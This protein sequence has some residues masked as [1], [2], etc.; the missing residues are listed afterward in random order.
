MERGRGP[1]AGSRQGGAGPRMSRDVRISK[2]VPMSSAQR[3]LYLQCQRP[4]GDRAYHL[5][6]LARLRGPFPLDA[7]RAFAGRMAERHESLRGAFRMENGEFLCEV[8]ETVNVAFTVID[9]AES[10]LEAVVE[11]YDQPFRLDVP[12]LFRIVI[13]RL[14]G[15][16]SILLFN[17]HHLVFDGYSGSLIARDILLELE[18]RALP[19]IERT[20]SDFVE[21]ERNFFQ[22]VEYERQRDFWLARYPQAPRRLGFRPDFAPTAAKSFAGDY[23]IVHLD[24]RE[25]KAFSRSQGATLFMTLLAAFY[26][27]LHRL[28]GQDEITVG[29][30]VSPREA[31]GFQNVVG[32]FANTLPLTCRPDPGTGFSEFLQGVR[33]MVFQA[34]QNADYPFE[35]LV[36]Q[37]PFREPGERNPLF[38]VVF[39]FE[40][41]AQR[42]VENFRGVGMETLDVFAKVSMFDLAIDLV[43]YEDQVRFKVE[44]ATSVFREE[45]L[46]GLMDAFI[47]VIEQVCRRPDIPIGE[48]EMLSDAARERL[49]GFND[50]AHPLKAGWTFVDTWAQQAARSP[51]NPALRRE[52][53]TL[54]YGQLEARANR[55]ARYLLER[56]VGEGSV[57]AVALGRTPEWIVALLALWKIGAVYLPIDPEHPAGRIRHML[58]DSGAALVL[59]L[60]RW[61]PGFAG[62]PRVLALDSLAAGPAGLPSDD[63]GRRPRPDQP[64]YI[65]YT[66]GSTGAPKGVL[67]EHSAV[68]AH[69]QALKGPYKLRPD[70]NVLQ[71]SSP[72]FDASL[73]Q[74]LVTLS[75]G[76]CLVQLDTALKTPSALLD[77]LAR[78]E[79]SVAEFPPAYLREM[80][81]ALAPHALQT[82][83]RLISGGDVLDTE[84]AYELAARLPPEARLL[85]FYGPTEAT[86]AATV[87]PAA[88]DLA[89]HAGRGLPIGKPLPNTHVHILDAGLRPLAPGLP[90]EL[91][92]AG[93]RLARGYLNR[94]ALTEERFV[95]VRTP[96]G[97][98][99]LYRTGD[100]AR[101]LPDGNIEFLGRMDRQVQLRGY[102]IELGEVEQ[103]LL[104]HPQVRDAVVVL[105][106]DGAPGL[107]AY[108]ALLAPDLDARGVREWLRE[109]LPEHMIPASFTF[110][111]AIPRNAEGK[112]ERQALAAEGGDVPEEPAD[113][114]LDALEWDLWRMWRDIL[115]VPRIGRNDVFFLIGGNSLG[116]IQVMAEVRNR[117]G[118]DLPLALLLKSPTIAVLAEYLRH[119]GR[120]A[121]RSGVVHLGGAGAGPAL[122]LI[123]GLGG[124]ILDLYELSTHLTGRLP[125][126][127]LEYPWEEEAPGVNDSVEG[128]ARHFLDELEPLV[129][130]DGCIL[131]GHS[132][133]GA[134]AFDLAR[135]IEARGRRPGALLLLD[136][137]VP[138]PGPVPL[139]E[140]ELLALT[141]DTLTAGV[142]PAEAGS[143]AHGDPHAQALALLKAAR[144][145]PDSLDLETF[146]GRVATIARRAEAFARY[147]PASS[148]TADIHLFRAR[149][150]GPDQGFD[151]EDG[152][153]SRH[154][155]GSVFVH[156]TPGGHFSM[157]KGGHAAELARRMLGL[158]SP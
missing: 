130:L 16:E 50:T 63:P 137:A 104:G 89:R 73:E 55:L 41:V 92:I 97:E 154:T 120:P 17:C 150:A 108:L 14:G 106:T 45:S 88:G 20:Y 78:E 142:P 72:T 87:F 79:V 33:R 144:R 59:T 2:R 91:C 84:L 34:M 132:F 143:P 105:D 128:L 124:S 99:R 27:V 82:V 21:W 25:A 56:G 69:L 109:R 31:G 58:S 86:M 80:L 158:V 15:A 125:C 133:G 5:L 119:A 61:R 139:T 81:P 70:D 93:E 94:D 146:R 66:S 46:R 1:C 151:Q 19:P 129:P 51:D 103:T 113:P 12:P 127:G 47:G 11:K 57:A 152:G 140:A 122:V 101:W 102:R 22:S 54:S 42:R 107:R 53:L 9:G 13:L 28:S 110:M 35:H 52:G 39:N 156:R 157:I 23:F 135:R 38:D 71:F 26:C 74:I 6:F 30:L 75:A 48:L 65:I 7:A 83:R 29:T 8:H 123:P 134:V 131:A 111:E 116:A 77:L 62:F 67:V 153:W 85:N 32:L 100:R 136:V 155:G 44:Y 3:R 126:H 18:G 43:E 117:Y 141:V 98:E 115:K 145:V 76:A 49:R 36:R 24:K 10:D 90:G 40:R 138:R 147:A 64:A 148:V 60:E 121:A 96:E 95:R 68:Q 37:L 112:L 118:V 114:P 149:E 4:D